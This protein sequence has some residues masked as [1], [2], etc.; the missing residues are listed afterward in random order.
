MPGERNYAANYQQLTV[1]QETLSPVAVEMEP[2]EEPMRGLT[3]SV[4]QQWSR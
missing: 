3:G 2:Q 1:D 4:I